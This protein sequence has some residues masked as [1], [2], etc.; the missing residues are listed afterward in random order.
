L[1]ALFTCRGKPLRGI[2]PD[3]TED[4]KGHSGPWI[5]KTTAIFPFPAAGMGP[6]DARKVPHIGV[7]IVEKRAAWEVF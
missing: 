1:S 6:L 3:L 4:Q 2:S 7:G 5:V